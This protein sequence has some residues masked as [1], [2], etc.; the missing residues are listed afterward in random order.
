MTKTIYVVSERS[1]EYNDEIYH[2][3][4]DGSGGKSGVS[5]LAFSSKVFAMVERDKKNLEWF[6][7]VTSGDRYNNLSN[8]TYEKIDSLFDDVSELGV[9]IDDDSITIPENFSEENYAKLMNAMTGD[10]DLPWIVSE[11]VYSE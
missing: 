1:F 9:I 6:K 10:I 3:P 2:L 5:K 8:Y 7:E 11:V 4:E